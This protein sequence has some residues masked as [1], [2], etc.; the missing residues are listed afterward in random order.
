MYSTAGDGDSKAR[1]A[2]T[3]TE[4]EINEKEGMAV[5]S[6]SE[7]SQSQS[8]SVLDAS[9][10]SSSQQSLSNESGDELTEGDI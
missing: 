8:S 6:L 4:E 3:N 7:E 9:E 10:Q 5:G 1:G 2:K